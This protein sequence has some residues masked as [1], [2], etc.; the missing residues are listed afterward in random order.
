MSLIKQMLDEKAHDE[1]S[2]IAQDVKEWEARGS[3]GDGPFREV[4]EEALDRMNPDWREDGSPTYTLVMD[5]VAYYVWRYLATYE[6]T[7]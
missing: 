7:A 3:I 4:T 1:V 5:R 6:E 2:A